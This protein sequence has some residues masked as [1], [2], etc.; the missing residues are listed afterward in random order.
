VK[1]IAVIDE[2]SSG[3]SG[4][5]RKNIKI[6]FAGWKRFRRGRFYHGAPPE[7]RNN[8]ISKWKMKMCIKS[9]E[10]FTSIEEMFYYAPMP[11]MVEANVNAV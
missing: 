3:T 1:N 8:D 9:L 11:L 5:C 2:I 7:R 10:S 4:N 6:S